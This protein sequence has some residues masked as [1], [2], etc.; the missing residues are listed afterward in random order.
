[1]TGPV[2]LAALIAALLGV[3][4]AGATEPLRLLSWA[5][6]IAPVT[7]ES[8]TA[9]T[10]IEVI[11]DTYES[12]EPVEA[13]LL[14]GGSGYDIAIVSWEYV[15]RLVDSGAI[16]PVPGEGMLARRGIEPTVSAL[17]RG[18]DPSG[19]FAVPYLW[20]TTG[21]GIDSAAVEARLPEG[22]HDD[23]GLLF[24]PAR[25]ERLADCG[26]GVIDSAEEVIG[27]ALQWL[28]H[29]P[30]TRDPEAR[31]AAL[32][33]IEA[34]APHVRLFSSSLIAPLA[35]GD[36]C[37]V[38]DWSPDAIVATV[39]AAEQG[40]VRYILPREGGL[41][42]ADVLVMPADGR[43]EAAAKAFIDYTLRPDISAANASY[44]WAGTPLLAALPLVDAPVR[45][46][47]FL[48][49]DDPAHARLGHVAILSSVEKAGLARAWAQIKIGLP[50]YP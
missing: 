5:D 42:W 20:G 31:R 41:V 39:E 2:R 22:P 29:D 21:L 49:A 24:D 15:G 26:I 46:H 43:S 7:I 6:Y 30:A 36:L 18:T 10:G 16:R 45:E 44:N 27:A 47:P 9:E 11:V 37:L 34:I 28:G 50:L 4:P 23:W 3:L 13:M 33:A 1:M 17:L 35:E 32:L 19:L 48:G 8:F 14:A 40:R 12:G 25:A 38:L